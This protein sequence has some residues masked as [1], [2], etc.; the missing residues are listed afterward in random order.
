MLPEASV[1]LEAA[2]RSVVAS[3]EEG[4]RRKEGQQIVA[5]VVGGRWEGVFWRA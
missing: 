2:I 4:H 1:W 5:G 3:W